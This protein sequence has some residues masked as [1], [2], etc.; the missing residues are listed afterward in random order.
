MEVQLRP[1]LAQ[2]Y[3]SVFEGIFSRDWVKTLLLPKHSQTPQTPS[4][5]ILS[6]DLSVW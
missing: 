2:V 1:Y 4:S 3:H 6:I 5:S